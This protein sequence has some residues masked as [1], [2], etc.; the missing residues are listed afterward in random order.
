MP[1]GALLRGGE[2]P[3]TPVGKRTSLCS[4]WGEKAP[5]TVKGRLAAIR[6]FH[7]TSGL[8]DPFAQLPRVALVVAGL[9]KRYGTKEA[10]ARDPRDVAMA[11]YAPAR[12]DART[13]GG[14]SPMG[15]PLP[16]VFLP[17]PC[18]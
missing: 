8:P 9:K 11:L 12:R 18:L 2:S 10:E 15:G 5:G 17:P 7:I 6:A 16:S 3:H 1:E 13:N 4:T 14:R